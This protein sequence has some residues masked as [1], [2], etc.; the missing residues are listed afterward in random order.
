V[1]CSECDAGSWNI[2]IHCKEQAISLSIAEALALRIS[3]AGGAASSESI[4]GAGR[5]KV[6]GRSV[7]G[8]AN[9]STT[10]S[11]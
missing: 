2:R 4:L 9:N 8:I 11:W 10:C 3:F 7:L 6:V 5:V 1:A